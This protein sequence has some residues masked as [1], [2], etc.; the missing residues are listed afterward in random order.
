MIRGRLRRALHVPQPGAQLA[1]TSPHTVTLVP[2]G[3]VVQSGRAHATH[4]PL[5][6]H[7]SPAGHVP[8]LSVAPQPF[9]TLPHTRPLHAFALG[10]QHAIPSQT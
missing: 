10:V 3:I 4:A 5:E 7:E 8:Q 2:H 1:T 6:L 9:E